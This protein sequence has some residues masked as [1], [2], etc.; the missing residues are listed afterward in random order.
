MGIIKTAKQLWTKAMQVISLQS[1]GDQIQRLIG[2]DFRFGTQSRDFLLKAY[3]LNPYVFMVIDRICQRLVQIDKRLFDRSQK[4]IE[5]PEFKELLENPNEKE[6]GDA[7]LYRASA[8]LL[9][10]GECFIIR[11]QQLGEQDQYFVPINYNVTI[12]QDTKG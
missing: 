9:A 12:N 11:F 4:E 8:T 2:Q 5:N 6:D 10:T 3:G 1:G 7:Y